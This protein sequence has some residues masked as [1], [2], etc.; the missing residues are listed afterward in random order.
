MHVFKTA[1][2]AGLI[3][4]TVLASPMVLADDT[5]WYGGLNAGRARASID[6]QRI[7][8]GLLGSG[9]ATSTIVDDNSATGFKVFGGYQFNRHFAL[10]G[11]YFDLGRFGYRATTVPA[12]TL[13]GTIRLK[14]LNLDTVG[15]L[16]LTDKLSA[17][18][19]IGINYADARDRFSGSGAVNVLDTAPQKRDT[20]IK[21]GLG[22]Q[23]AVTDALNLRV[24]AERYR[25][26]DAIG[27]RGDVDLVSVGLVYRFGDKSSAPV[28]RTAE[29][30][31][32]LPPPVAVVVPAPAPP[33]P[34]PRKVSFS[35]DSLFAFDRA[36]ITPAGKL[37]LGKFASDLIGTDYDQIKVTGHTDRIG[38]HA[39]NL[40]LS[41]RR[42]D[43]VKNELVTAAG[44][45]AKRITTSGINGAEP[46]TKPGD[47]VGTRTTP[48]LIACLQPDRRVEVEVSGTR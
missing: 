30:V 5:G 4:L 7:T 26:N 48:A 10:E 25:V 37:V 40:K 21:F 14:G 19:R 17:F 32:Y 9:F 1:G 8:S 24:E 39:Y 29:P 13:D 41:S 45:P 12:G 11:G 33:P 38:A 6:D 22:L 43:A 27:N 34:V 28:P 2:H 36:D 23:Y 3:A 47:C 18:G 46:V 31:A 20:N 42:A 16:P 15:I 35:A 44:I